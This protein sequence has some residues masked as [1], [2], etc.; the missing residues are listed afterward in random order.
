MFPSI[1][2]SKPIDTVSPILYVRK[3]DINSVADEIFLLLIELSKSPFLSL[4]LTG[5]SSRMPT[6]ATPSPFDEIS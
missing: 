6:T 5:E 1:S 2:L 3:V 4:S